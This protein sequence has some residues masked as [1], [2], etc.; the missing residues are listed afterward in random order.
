LRRIR[1]LPETL[2]NGLVNGSNTKALAEGKEAE[3]WRAKEKG[4]ECGFWKCIVKMAKDDFY[5]VSYGS[6]DVINCKINGKEFNEI[7]TK[8]RIRPMN[9]N[10]YLKSNPFFK[11]MVEVPKDL[12][13]MNPEVVKRGETHKHFKSALKLVSVTYDE[14]SDRLVCIG[15]AHNHK[16]IAYRNALKGAE[17][18]AET[19]Y[20]ALRQ[21]VELITQIG[22]FSQQYKNLDEVIK[23]KENEF[24]ILVR[25][26]E[27]FMRYAIGYMGANIK[28]VLKMPGILS[29]DR[30]PGVEENIFRVLATN[31]NSLRSAKTMLQISESVVNVSRDLVPHIIGKGGGLVQEMTDKSGLISIK[32][33][34]EDPNTKPKSYVPFHLIG[35]HEALENGRLLISFQMS[36]VKD[37]LEFDKKFNPKKGDKRRTH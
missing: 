27:D 30:V 3:V 24:E 28:S 1:L 34:G 2:A 14:K 19:H 5:G 35:T 22:I 31:R 26:E 21:E 6:D 7:V 29:V 4:H 25:V 8:D 16:D 15:F 37:N 36:C 9:P 11:F 20:K 23:I 12:L 17:V 33:K 32:I 18:L 10:P 13:A